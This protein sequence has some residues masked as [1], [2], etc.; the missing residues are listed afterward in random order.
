MSIIKV[1]DLETEYIKVEAEISFLLFHF[2][3][4]IYKI[5]KYQDSISIL[6]D[7]K[8]DYRLALEDLAE[9]TRS[10]EDIASKLLILFDKSYYIGREIGAPANLNYKILT[11]HLKNPSK[12]YP[13]GS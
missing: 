13:I 8:K 10:F 6:I 4:L 5:R 12:H 9:S 3:L 7:E 11:K 2:D 1:G